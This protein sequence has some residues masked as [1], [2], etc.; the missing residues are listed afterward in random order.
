MDVS[1][2]SGIEMAMMSVPRHAPKKSNTIN[3]VNAA[4]ITPSFTTPLTAVRT[5]MD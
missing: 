3:A 4:A 1:T 5:K 2:E